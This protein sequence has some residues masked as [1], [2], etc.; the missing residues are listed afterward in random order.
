MID[1]FLLLGRKEMGTG[2]LHRDAARRQRRLEST[3]LLLPPH[4][5]ANTGLPLGIL[6]GIPTEIPAGLAIEMANE[7]LLL[8]NLKNDD[9]QQ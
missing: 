8:Y 1:S 3:F 7:L 2:T 9:D 4:C 5:A 6:T